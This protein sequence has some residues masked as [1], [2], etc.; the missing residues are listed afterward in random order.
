MVVSFFY[1]IIQRYYISW[2]TIRQSKGL[3]VY[4]NNYGGEFG[5]TM[6]AIQR[7]IVQNQRWHCPQSHLVSVNY[8]ILE[9]ISPLATMSE[10]A[11]KN[12]YKYISSATAANSAAFRSCWSDFVE[13]NS[14]ELPP[15]PRNW[16]A[17]SSPLSVF[18]HRHSSWFYKE[19]HFLS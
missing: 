10:T 11:I 4:R 14:T 12:I 16:F 7:I 1:Y 5:Q 18:F 15:Q 17:G 8:F 2:Q 13:A 3:G 6:T 19:H 9:N